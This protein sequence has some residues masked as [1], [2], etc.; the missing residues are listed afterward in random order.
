MLVA[1]ALSSASLAVVP[2]SDVEGADL[3]PAQPYF[4]LAS[5]GSSRGKAP[6]V[7]PLSNDGFVVT[8][9]ANDDVVARLFDGPQSPSGAEIVVSDPL[10]GGAYPA[11]SSDSTDAFVVVWEAEEIPTRS[12]DVFAR[13]FDSSGGALGPPF[14]VNTT[15]LGFQT[16]ARIAHLGN[17]SFVVVWDGASTASGTSKEVW[18]QLYD[19]TG[20][21]VGGEL[22]VNE[23]TVGTQWLATVAALSGGGFVVG[24][25]SGPSGVPSVFARVFDASGT[26]LGSELQVDDVA[27]PKPSGSPTVAAAPDGGFVV[28]W[29]DQ[30]NGSRAR[31]FDASGSAAGPSFDLL[32]G[33]DV[34]GDVDG[35][36]FTT[37][38]Q[39]AAFVVGNFYG[40]SG[41]DVFVRTFD[42]SGAPTS[43]PATINDR[44][45]GTQQAASAKRLSGGSFVVV[46]EDLNYIASRP[47]SPA[48]RA[49]GQRD[50]DVSAD[51]T[52]DRCVGFDDAVDLDADGVPDGCDPCVND[53]TQ[54]IDEKVLVSINNSRL[55]D[56]IHKKAHRLKVKGRLTLP[57]APGAFGGLDLLSDGMRVRVESAEGRA[58][59]DVTLPGGAYAGQGSAGWRS[60]P[61]GTKWIFRDATGARDDGIA[62]VK[63]I[64]RSGSQPNRVEVQVSGLDGEYPISPDYLPVRGIVVLGGPTASVAGVCGETS[65]VEADCKYR[66]TSLRCKSTD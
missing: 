31:R 28:G 41:S 52:C 12:V 32:A 7:S 10:V 38:G 25:Y 18:A 1:L 24:W 19:S 61:A 4:D 40:A 62:R 23:N 55:I 64:D 45:G 54:Y 46:W 15:V 16:H 34:G 50:C 21:T 6:D 14:R 56:T 43:G 33:V 57:G 51:F 39:L 35:L 30:G 8:W 26:A 49:L 59:S 11:I 22:Q 27:D 29:H 2:P 37:D 36:A 47:G 60:N 3:A 65:F 66:K 53:G 9:L 17:D 42:A 58:I 44:L 48:I 13:R 20:V 63:V 5:D